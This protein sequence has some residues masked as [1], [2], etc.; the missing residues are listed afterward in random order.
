ME[1]GDDVDPGGGGLAKAR[2][3]MGG[4]SAA[5]R[6]GAYDQTAHAGGTRR[7]DGEIRHAR[8]DAASGKP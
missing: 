4:Q 5:D 3:P 1:P 7:R 2:N 8:V 6:G